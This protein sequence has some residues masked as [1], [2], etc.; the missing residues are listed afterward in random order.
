M[1]SSFRVHEISLQHYK[2]D[3]TEFEAL[4]ANPT[5]KKLQIEIPVGISPVICLLKQA[6]KAKPG[7]LH[8]LKIRLPRLRPRLFN[9][10]FRLPQLHTINVSLSGFTHIPLVERMYEAWKKQSCE[11]LSNLTVDLNALRIRTID[12]IHKAMLDEMCVKYV[13]SDVHRTI[14]LLKFNA[15]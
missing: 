4:L 15:V 14:M 3:S 10:L 8:E 2:T 1:H 11:R 5:L 9:A 13:W 6:I 12:D 7:S